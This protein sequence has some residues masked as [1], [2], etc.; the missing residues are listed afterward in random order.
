MQF[1]HFRY[2]KAYRVPYRGCYFHS[3]LELKYALFL[4]QDYRYLREPF[5][6][7]YDPKTYLTTD[8]FKEGIKLYTP[9]FLIRCKIS[10]K[11]TLVEIKPDKLKHSPESKTY[12]DIA[13]HYIERVGL[14]ADFRV[15]SEKDFQLSPQMQ[16]RFEVFERHKAQYESIDAFRNADRKYN[17]Q[18]IKY[19]N[20]VPAFPNDELNKIEY[21]RYVRRGPL[22]VAA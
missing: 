9:D 15:I 18:S 20:S 8:Y 14:N 6:I 10:G 22:V 11:A 21:A 3:L 17:A 2:R 4:E 1:K 7:G 19:F 5:I 12:Y 16:Q 13:E